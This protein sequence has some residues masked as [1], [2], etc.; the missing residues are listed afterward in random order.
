LLRAALARDP[1]AAEG[2]T[3]MLKSDGSRFHRAS[4]ARL[5]AP[6]VTVGGVVEALTAAAADRD[7]LVRAAACASLAEPPAPPAVRAALLRAARDDVRLV[8]MQA[9]WALRQTASSDL[10][11]ADRAAVENARREW[12]AAHEYIRDTVAGNYNLGVFHAALG[13]HDRAVAAY[14]AALALRPQEL[15]PRQNLAMLL[16]QRG[17]TDE[18]EKEFREITTLHRSWAGGPF[19]LGLLM[20]EQ[21]R[22]DDAVLAF[23]EATRRDPAHPRALYNLGLAYLRTGRTDDARRALRAAAT[24]EQ[25]RDDALAALQLVDGG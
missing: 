20:I 6:F 25:S 8:R 14:R 7:A 17:L 18:A 13:D 19:S 9:A 21:D 10:E 5:L 11:P 15:E 23:E 2:L 4:A 22:L 3:V 16:A 24:L 1:A 12:I